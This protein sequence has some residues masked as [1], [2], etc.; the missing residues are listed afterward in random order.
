MC[1]NK[2]LKPD[3]PCSGTLEQRGIKGR[4]SSVAVAKIRGRVRLTRYNRTQAIM[5][6]EANRELL[7]LMTANA[8]QDEQHVIILF[9]HKD[10]TA[11][12]AGSKYTVQV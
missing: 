4:D 7:I 10:I 12:R 11:D 3:L 1:E 9:V 8:F 5:S 2:R 6:R